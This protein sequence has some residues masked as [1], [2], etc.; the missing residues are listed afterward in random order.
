LIAAD[1]RDDAADSGSG[2]SGQVAP[3]PTPFPLCR[4][5]LTNGLNSGVVKG[6]TS[7]MAAGGHT[8]KE[9]LLSYLGIDTAVARPLLCLRLRG[10]RRARPLNH[11]AKNRRQSGHR[12]RWIFGPSAFRL[13]PRH[14]SPVRSSRAQPA[15]A[16]QPNHMAGGFLANSANSRGARKRDI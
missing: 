14:L 1:A 4:T 2:S 6:D 10:R 7:L 9:G 3:H 8:I 13:S 15:L 11:R 5:C 12:A 16:P